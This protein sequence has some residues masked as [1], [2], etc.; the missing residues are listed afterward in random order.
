ME[1]ADILGRPISLYLRMLRII[2]VEYFQLAKICR[3]G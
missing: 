3:K 2:F 1:I